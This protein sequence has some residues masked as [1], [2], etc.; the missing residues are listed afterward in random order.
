MSGKKLKTSRKKFIALIK[1][2]AIVSNEIVLDFFIDDFSFNSIEW[3]KEKNKIIL[4]KFEEGDIDL[5]YD[6]DQL[7]NNIKRELYLFLIRNFLN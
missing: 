3:V 6:F 4:H 5:E 1:L 7:P 2:L